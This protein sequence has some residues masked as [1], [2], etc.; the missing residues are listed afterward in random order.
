MTRASNIFEPR[1]C[2]RCRVAPWRSHRREQYKRQADQTSGA[3]AAVSSATLAIGLSG[4]L[5]DD[6]L[7]GFFVRSTFDR[8]HRPVSPSSVAHRGTSRVGLCAPDGLGGLMMSASI[9]T[10]VWPCLL[11]PWFPDVGRCSTGMSRR[12]LPSRIGSAAGALSGRGV[13]FTPRRMMAV[14]YEEQRRCRYSIDSA[15]SDNYRPS[16]CGG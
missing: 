14:R 8:V 5:T 10:S 4:V 1:P 12:V 13:R 6:R 3:L 11:G 9:K 2:H 15:A 16:S 7:T